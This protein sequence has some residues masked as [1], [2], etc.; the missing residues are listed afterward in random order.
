MR[1]WL[2][3]NVMSVGKDLSIIEAAPVI[4]HGDVYHLPFG[5]LDLHFHLNKQL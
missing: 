4:I 3:P 1:V 2:L 5:Q